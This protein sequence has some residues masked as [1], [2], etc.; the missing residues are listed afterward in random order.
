MWLIITNKKFKQSRR[1]DRFFRWLLKN[2]LLKEYR[3]YK[4]IDNK[5]IETK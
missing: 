5:L 1:S 3:R 2:K 4:L